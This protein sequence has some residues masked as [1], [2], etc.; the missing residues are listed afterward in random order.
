MKATRNLQLIALIGTVLAGLTGTAQAAISLSNITK[1]PPGVH[2]P[3]DRYYVEQ[4]HKGAKESIWHNCVLYTRIFAPNLPT[5]LL[6]AKSKEKIIRTTTAKSGRVAVMAESEDWHL[7]YVTDVD[8][9]GTTRSITLVEANYKT[10]KLTRR[11]ATCSK[12]LDGCLKELKIKG[13]WY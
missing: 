9:A 12:S 8:D 7:G 5:G 3:Q 11:T 4:Y 1:L 6:N 2:G 10:G 13:F